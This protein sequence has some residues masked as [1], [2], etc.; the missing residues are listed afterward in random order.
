MGKSDGVCAAIVRGARV[1]RARGAATQIV[2]PPSE[3]M[4]R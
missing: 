3:D 4:F 2:R 1:V